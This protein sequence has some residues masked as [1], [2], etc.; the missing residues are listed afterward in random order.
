MTVPISND[1]PGYPET[2][3]QNAELAAMSRMLEVS[4]GCFSLSVAVCN[5]PALRDHL[6]GRLGESGPPEVVSVPKGTI[7]VYGV[8]VDRVKGTS[9]R[10]VFV[11]DLELSVPS[12]EPEQLT[13][14]SLNASRELWE[15]RFACPVVFWLPT[16]AANLLAIHAKDLWRYRSH[17]F[18]FVAE[19]TGES[20][21]SSPRSDF[22]L[23][24]AQNLSADEKR[25]RIEELEERIRDAGASP[26]PNLARFLAE[27]RREQGILHTLLG[28]LDRAEQMHR[29][30]CDI[31]RQLG[32]DLAL[33]ADYGNLGVVH[34]M[35]GDLEE[36][37][38]LFRVAL[39]LDEQSGSEKR[40]ART[41]GNLGNVFRQRENW[42]EAEQMYSR[43]LKI[44]EQLEL[45]E[46]VA[47]AHCN[48]G[49]VHRVRGSLDEAEHM[50]RKALELAEELGA[51]EGMAESYTGLGNALC[52]RGD[53][54]E[55]ERMYGFALQI[56]EQLG[57]RNGIAT[58]YG[59]L[60]NVDYA[61]GDL[62][63]AER[64]YRM[65]LDIHKELGIREEVARHC[66]N[67]GNVFDIRGDVGRAEEFWQNALD[68]YEQI[69][70]TDK[71]NLMRARLDTLREA[72]D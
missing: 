64:A 40:V 53:F 23:A 11:V 65:A 7:D 32:E 18:E 61:R 19:Q 8:V 63:E 13:L 39:E 24:V 72:A 57:S 3:R 2:A 45:R 28:N 52:A 31:D 1:M 14:V 29:D 30:A 51:R 16:Y 59:N 26:E 10:A 42:D 12:R 58:S 69:R 66:L 62:D 4:E 37:E 36:A 43:G 48:L 55:A 20:I 46:D 49:F 44:F 6:I 47:I 34:E 5:S 60:G 21:E 33:A 38:R 15:Q 68:L 67:L 25:F 17:R 35:R 70:A 9:P 41:Y 56:F 54:G 71:V 27:W 22:S 50:Y